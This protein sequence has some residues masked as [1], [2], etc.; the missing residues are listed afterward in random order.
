VVEFKTSS[1]RRHKQLFLKYINIRR[2]CA[3]DLNPQH[4]PVAFEI[5]PALLS[6]N[7]SLLPGYIPDGDNACGVHGVG[8][9]K[10]LKK[11]INHYFPEARKLKIAYQ[12]HL[13]RRPIIASLL[14]MGSIGTI[15]QNQASDYDFW[16]CV[17]AERSSAADIQK[18]H[19]KTE[20]ISRWCQIQFDMEVHFFIMPIQ[21]IR[22]DDFGS[23]NEES[24]GSS[25]KKSLKEEFYR[26]ML[27][28][29]G[30]IPF[31]WVVPPAI[32]QADYQRYWNQW[33]Q[34]NQYD[35]DDFLELGYLG[36]IPREEFLGTILWHLSK[37][38]NNPF[39]ALIKMAMMESYLSDQID[40]PLLCDVIKKRVHEGRQSI[41]DLDPYLLML[42]TILNHYSQARKYERMELLRKAFYIKTQPRLN[43][44]KLI[45]QRPNYQIQAFKN[46]IK[47]WR[48]SLN[49]CEDLNQIENWSYIR[50]LKFATKINA[51]FSST[52]KQFRQESPKGGP[53]TINDHDLTLLGRKIHV[54][55][56]KHKN[57]IQLN[58]FLKKGGLVLERCIFRLEKN[59][60]GKLV[61]HL[62]DATRYPFEKPGKQ[63]IIFTSGRVARTAAW[64][65]TN[66]LYDLHR[67]E[68][69]M[70]P[71][72]SGLN[73]NDLIDLLKHMHAYFLPALSQIKMGTRLQEDARFNQIMLVANLEKI[74][75]QD[76]GSGTDIIHNNTWGELFTETYPLRKAIKVTREALNGMD[77]KN[78][79]ARLRLHIPKRLQTTSIRKEIYQAILP[80]SRTELNLN[81]P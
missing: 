28:V 72:P 25:Q 23:V 10:N 20:K 48:W 19:R 65:V 78:P 2:K 64:L 44:L 39:K 56:A 81:M 35:R 22:N 53:Q 17:D 29:C 54:L 62:Y 46:L 80:A 61:W 14:L 59:R 73:V 12:R 71:N 79:T 50:Q 60:N 36:D 16:V 43:R 69:E 41:L 18:L 74:P 34:Q 27:L 7:D 68:I 21:D 52:Y 66:G 58:P 49:L 1:I 37:G 57:K 63:S 26:T 55:F 6:L 32:S 11:R 5:I 45:S 13:I 15:T 8:S 67:T 24:A 75:G 30:K 31:W 33:T 3:Y 47:E 9:A 40:G 51:F 4:A 42:A 77:A 70:A 38:I 76:E